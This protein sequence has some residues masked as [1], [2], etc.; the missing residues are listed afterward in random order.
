MPHAPMT[1]AAL[2]G[3]PATIRG[4]GTSPS[5]AIEHAQFNE[6]SAGRVPDQPYRVLPMTPRLQ[7]H[8]GRISYVTHAACIERA[9]GTLDHDGDPAVEDA[10]HELFLAMVRLSNLETAWEQADR[11]GDAER[12]RELDAAYDVAEANV[13]LAR[14]TV[15]KARDDAGAHA[16][17][18]VTA[19]PSNRRKRGRILAVGR[20]EVE[21]RNRAED[22]MCGDGPAVR[23][24]P[25]GT[26]GYVGLVLGRAVA[27]G[28]TAEEAWSSL[29][30]EGLSIAPCTER[31]Y[32]HVEEHGEPDVFR[33]TRGGLHDLRDAA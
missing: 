20:T 14:E 13:E 25:D 30:R 6:G 7:R 15:R 12:A 21:A 2:L 17:F 27:W 19:V 1:H 24:E 10:S 31:L 9:D 23:I 26:G 3:T 32:R 4:I 29:D 8:V 16:G 11:A 18:V 22:V 28:Q 33:R 5:D